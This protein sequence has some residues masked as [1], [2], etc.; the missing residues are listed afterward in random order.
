MQAGEFGRRQKGKP[1][2]QQPKRET[3]TE[4]RNA[5]GQQEAKAKRAESDFSNAIKVNERCGGGTSSPKAPL[6]RQRAG[7]QRSPPED[8]PTAQ[9]SPPKKS[10]GM[11]RTLTQRKRPQ[12]RATAR[13]AAQRLLSTSPTATPERARGEVAGPRSKTS[14]AASAPTDAFGQGVLSSRRA[15]ANHGLKRGELL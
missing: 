15:L 11:Q 3:R 5:R 2:R 10:Q 6:Y 7:S 1:P 8:S 4:R 13:F 12:R 14:K 9:R